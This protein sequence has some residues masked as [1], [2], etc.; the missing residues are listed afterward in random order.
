MTEPIREP[1][2]ARR[3]ARVLCSDIVAYAGDQLRLGL[4]KDDL[5]ER[6]GPEIERARGYYARQVDPALP[7]A[8]RIFDFAL[9]DVLIYGSRRVPTHI[10]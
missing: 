4:E 3:L 2:R 5:F 9:V 6:L 7:D 8:L 10:W 1:W